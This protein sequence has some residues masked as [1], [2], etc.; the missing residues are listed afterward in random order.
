[1]NNDQVEPKSN[2][3]NPAVRQI[4]AHGYFT[5]C[6]PSVF[7][8][9]LWNRAASLQL[10]HNQSLALAWSTQ[11]QV[12]SSKGGRTEFWFTDSL[13]LPG[14]DL[15]SVHRPPTCRGRLARWSKPASESLRGPDTKKAQV[16]EA[17]QCCHLALL[18]ALCIYL[19]IYLFCLYYVYVIYYYYYFF[20]GGQ[21]WWSGGK[22]KTC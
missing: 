6:W 13:Q 15:D 17:E 8:W 22:V 21:N 5:A 11:N 9:G 14:L 10:S 1:M 12:N 19:S 2:G 18:C 16:P 20:G 7:L 3:P 4:Y